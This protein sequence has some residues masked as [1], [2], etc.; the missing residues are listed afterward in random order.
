[1]RARLGGIVHKL[2]SCNSV[3]P[4]SEVRRG[5]KGPSETK[6]HM[7]YNFRCPFHSTHGCPWEV[8]VRILKHQLD[9]GEKSGE[10]EPVLVRMCKTSEE[11]K[12]RC[13]TG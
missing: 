1:M 12:L 13:G 4:R 7:V 8:R 3:T 9:Q 6:K 10:K 11:R 2:S 5:G